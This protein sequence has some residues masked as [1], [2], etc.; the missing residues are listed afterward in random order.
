MYSKKRFLVLLLISQSFPTSSE[1]IEEL[2]DSK[3]SFQSS[4]YGKDLNLAL[5]VTNKLDAKT[6]LINKQ[7][8]FRVDWMPFGGKKCLAMVLQVFMNRC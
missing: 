7:N 3:Y 6:I 1:L 2:N 5:E 4:F 8:A